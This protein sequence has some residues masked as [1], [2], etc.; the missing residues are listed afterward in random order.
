MATEA[1]KHPWSDERANIC[2]SGVYEMDK[3][4]R[5]LP[6]LVSTDA[7]EQAHYAVRAIAGRL[8]RISSLLLS[9]LGDDAVSSEE[10]KKYVDFNNDG[11]G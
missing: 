5:M 1:V 3:I 9:G 4:V 8:L 2:L 11:Q 10:L 6:A 7:D